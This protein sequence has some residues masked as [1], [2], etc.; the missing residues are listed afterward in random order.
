[1]QLTP[2]PA[3]LFPAA[4]SRIKFIASLDLSSSTIQNGV[5]LA[6]IGGKN[7]EIDVTVSGSDHSALAILKMRRR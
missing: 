4:K 1:M 5:S 2:I 6:R 3:E 7:V